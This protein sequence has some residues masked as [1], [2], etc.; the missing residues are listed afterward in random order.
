MAGPAPPGPPKAEEDISKGVQTEPK[1]G[2]R[3]HPKNN[4]KTNAEKESESIPNVCQ[5]YTKMDAEKDETNYTISQ[6]AISVFL[7]RV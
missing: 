4:A 3:G 7:Q 2:K 1:V 6:P 5:N